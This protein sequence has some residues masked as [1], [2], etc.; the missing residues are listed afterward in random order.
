LKSP[1]SILRALASTIACVALAGYVSVLLFP[2]LPAAFARTFNAWGLAT[3][4]A[5]DSG[6]R[7][8]QLV[9]I[10]FA[11]AFLVM[12]PAAL[13]MGMVFPLVAWLWV[14]RRDVVGK[15]VGTVYGANTVGSI[16]GSIVGGFVIVPLA[17]LQGGIL[18][19]VGAGAT[20]AAALTWT[21]QGW[22]RARSATVTGAAMAIF[23]LLVGLRP[24]WDPVVMNSGIYQYAPDLRGVSLSAPEF[25]TITHDKV[26][27]IDYEEGLTANV[28]V[29]R[30]PT[31]GNVWLSIN[32]KI[33]ASTTGDL[34]TQL[35]LGHLPML[36]AP[37]RAASGD[38]QAAVIGYATGIT[39]GA[40]TRYKP[41]R[42]AAVEIE[43][44]VFRASRHFDAFNYNALA[45]PVVQPIVADGRTFLLADSNQYDVIVSEPSSPWMSMAANLFTRE[46]F[47]IGRRRLAP[48][49]VFCQWIQL[50]GLPQEDLKSLMK[51]FTEVFPKTVVF[52][53]NP[54]Q[55]IIILG[56]ETAVPVD[57]SRLAES[58][59]DPDV[60][61]D[62]ARIGVKNAED[63]LAYYVTDDQGARAFVGDAPLNTDDNARIEFRAPL[64]MHTWSDTLKINAQA[65]RGLAVDPLTHVSGVP[66]DTVLLTAS[67]VR[68][69]EAF[70]NRRMFDRAIRAV[71]RGLELYPAQEG[72]DRLAAYEKAAQ[73]AGAE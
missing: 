26:E 4:G 16:V 62:L 60:A 37:K 35:L 36:F 14:G 53:G 15:A 38:R 39:T 7:A 19:A 58:L 55:D 8:L 28:L 47:D 44:A 43:G 34:E 68:L 69:S 52:W 65:L 59:R 46:F 48:G 29:G 42:V 54:G 61:A 17:G 23:A 32:G 73:A 67:Y 20:L 5:I 50:Y 21:F 64:S 9:S 2:R 45:N 49:G 66:D 63:L 12:F 10:E 24:S 22:T 3:P 30:N 13:C 11:F 56:S 31:N 71:K 40:V 27:V 72:Y 25:S 33:D 6:T 57:L 1:Q 51:T 41:G 70:F 18:A